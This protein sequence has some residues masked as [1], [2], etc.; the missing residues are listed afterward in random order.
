MAV[1]KGLLG[2]KIGMT[3][4]FKESK[5]LPVTVISA[6]PCYVMAVKRA[7]TDGY[8]AIQLGYEQAKPNKR[9]LTKPRLGEFNKLKLKPLKNVREIRIEDS[10]VLDNYRVGQELRINIF[11]QGEFLDIVARSKGKGFQGGVKRWGWR[12][13]PKSHGSRSHRAIGSIGQSSSPS[14]VFKGLHMAGHM[15]DDNVTVQNVEIVDLDL[16]NN[17]I[18]IKGSIPGARN[19]KI[20]LRNAKK[21]DSEFF[22]P[23]EVEEE[24]VEKDDKATEEESKDKAV[25]ESVDAQEEVVVKEES[26][27]NAEVEN[28][29]TIDNNIK[30]EEIAENK[31][32]KEESEL[33]TEEDKKDNE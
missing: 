30:E 24:E 7:E 28:R 13:G 12:I 32:A 18:L 5:A 17:L 11:K 25:E 9:R 4:I 31:V 27:D 10:S 26:K 20:I 19:S 23:Q 6:G 29:D 22:E 1:V 2:K 15:G 21:K 3:Q 33:K 8:N 16:E 14:R